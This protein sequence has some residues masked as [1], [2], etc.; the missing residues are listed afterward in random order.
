MAAITRVENT[1]DIQQTLVDLFMRKR[2]EWIGC[3]CEVF[4]TRATASVPCSRRA[5][6]REEEEEE[7]EI[8]YDCMKEDGAMVTITQR[9]LV[10]MICIVSYVCV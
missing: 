7:A 6:Y 9:A 10:A 2:D 1:K 3:G 5:S 8:R 4:S